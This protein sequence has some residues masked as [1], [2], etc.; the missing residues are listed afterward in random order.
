MRSIKP[1]LDTILDA[2]EAQTTDTSTELASEPKDGALPSQSSSSD[3]EHE[4]CD[5]TSAAARPPP[6]ED[7]SETPVVEGEPRPIAPSLRRCTRQ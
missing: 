7:V 2:V 4:A 6:L 3:E 5:T 1:E